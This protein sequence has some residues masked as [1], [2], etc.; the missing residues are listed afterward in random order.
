V[1]VGPAWAVKGNHITVN[2][3][4]KPIAG[5]QRMQHGRPCFGEAEPRILSS[6]RGLGRAYIKVCA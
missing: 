3:D 6:S 4:L 5:D 1:I 2:P